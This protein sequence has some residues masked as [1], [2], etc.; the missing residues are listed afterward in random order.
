MTWPKHK[1]DFELFLFQ[2]VRVLSK[3]MSGLGV[4]EAKRP[5]D[6]WGDACFDH[7]KAPPFSCYGGDRA[8]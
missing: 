8:I 1:V 4:S 3:A 7:D 2:T 5:W 6:L